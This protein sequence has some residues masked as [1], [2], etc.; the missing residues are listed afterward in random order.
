MPRSH[1]DLPLHLLD[2]QLPLLEYVQALPLFD[3]SVAPRW[4]RAVVRAYRLLLRVLSVVREH[5]LLIEKLSDVGID[6]V[7]TAPEALN[8]I[9]DRSLP[10]KDFHAFNEVAFESLQRKPR[11]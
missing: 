11:N 8:E 3:R 7:Q 5:Y 6:L 10:A 4:R 2:L 9:L 1:R